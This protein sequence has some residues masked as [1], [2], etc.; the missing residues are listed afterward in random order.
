MDL[1]HEPTAP[2]D[3]MDIDDHPVPTDPTAQATTHDGDAEM[4]GD[5]EEYGEYYEAEDGDG[6]AEGVEGGVYDEDEEMH[7]QLE[8]DDGGMGDKEFYE[9]TAPDGAEHDE[10]EYTEGRTVEDEDG[11]APEIAKP[12][13]GAM[14]RIAPAPELATS[15]P[16]AST[17]EAAKQ[18]SRQSSVPADAADAALDTEASVAESSTSAIDRIEAI[19]GEAK[20]EGATDNSNGRVATGGDPASSEATATAAT[21][22]P[23]TAELESGSH[24]AQNY[25]DEA[26]DGAAADIGQE[27]AGEETIDEAEEEGDEDED[28]EELLTIHNLP[29]VLVHPPA[30]P[31]KILFWTP[32]DHEVYADIIDAELD[33]LLEGQHEAYGNAK[34]DM[35]F[36]QIKAELGDH[37]EVPVGVEMI[38]EERALGLRMGEVSP[39]SQVRHL[40]MS[41]QGVKADQKARQASISNHPT[42]AAPSA[43]L[44]RIAPSCASVPHV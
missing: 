27:E 40:Y 25:A 38:L 1:D 28:I 30:G 23:G 6:E 2:A 7:D 20:D 5:D 33:I 41:I 29:P 24:A 9:E 44:V 32:E 12:A 37:V 34:L 13:A 36:A 19:A 16:S 10:T 26:D 11:D 4:E 35:V 15:R 43:S 17:E 39:A 22:A 18:Q 8:G 42:R 14:A 31:P 21:N 3:G